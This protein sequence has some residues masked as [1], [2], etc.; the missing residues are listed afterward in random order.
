MLVIGGG[1]GWGAASD[2]GGGEVRRQGGGVALDVEAAGAGMLAVEHTGSAPLRGSKVLSA[3]LP[4]KSGLRL[5]LRP[6]LASLD[7]A[8]LTLLAEYVANKTGSAR[9]L[10]GEHHG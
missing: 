3:K 7:A 5:S 6:K 2:L 1:R 4:A 9:H 8:A 10:T